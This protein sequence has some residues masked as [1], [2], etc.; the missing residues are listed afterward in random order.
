[1]EGLDAAALTILEES[2]DIPEG[3]ARQAFVRKRTEGAPLLRARVETLLG[4][5][6]K[7]WSS[8]ATEAFGQAR[9]APMALPERVGPFRIVGRIADGGM[10]SV[11]RGERDDGV[12]AQTVAIKFIRG[13]ISAP[14]AVARFDAERRILARLDH[15]SIARV[16]DGGTEAGRPWLAMEFV[17]G[18]PLNAALEA[19]DA[20][21]ADR[22]ATFLAVCE[23]VAFA[24]RNLIVHADIKPG[25]I[26]M[27]AD[28]AIKLL[29]FGIAR[30]IEDSEGD[31][32]Y[33]LT[34]G[35]A[36][37]ERA[38]G[39]APTIAGDVFSLGVLLRE[40]VPPPIPH[41][42]EAIAAC[43]TASDPA[44]RYPDVAALIADVRAYL[45]HF[46]VSA[47]RTSG[48]LYR[49]AK[50]LRRHRAGAIV[51]SAIL[52]LLATATVVSTGLYFRAEGARIE[53]E[54]RFL[55]VRDL[56]RFMLFDLYDDLADSPGT[57][58]SRARLAQMARF[59]LERLQQ[60]PNPPVDLRLDIAR[61][62][63]RLAA[64][65]GLSGV[66]SLGHPDRARDAL[67]RAEAVAA[68]ILA[69]RPD[70]AGAMEEMG[71]VL[72]GRWSLSADN[73][74]GAALN[75][76]GADWFQR[77]LRLEPGRAG[78][79]LGLLTARKN[80]GYDLV[81]LDRSAEAVPVLRAGLD[82]LRAAHF[83]PALAR[84]ARTLEVNMLGR[85]GD[86]VYYAGDVS[87]SLPWYREQ[88]RIV[89]AELARRQSVVW[90]DKLGESKFNLSGTL[91]EMPGHLPE[92]LAEAQAGVA[93]IERMLSFG[94]D[95]NLQMRLLILYSQEAL[96]LDSLGR[97][98]E[99]AAVSQ[100]SVDLRQTRLAGALQDPQRRRDLAAALPNHAGILAHAGRR[101]AAC[102]AARQAIG[103]WQALR[104]AGDLSPRDARTEIP[105][106]E[107]AVRTHCGWESGPAS[108]D[109]KL[110]REPEPGGLPAPLDGGFRRA[111]NDC[112]FGNAEADEIAK[113]D[114]AGELRRRALQLHQSGIER[115]HVQAGRRIDFEKDGRRLPL[116]A[117]FLADLVDHR[118]AQDARAGG[119]EM[120]AIL[121]AHPIELGNAHRRLVHQFGRLQGQE[122]RLAPQHPR[123]RRAQIVVQLGQHLV[124]L[125]PVVAHRRLPPS[126]RRESAPRGPACP[127]DGNVFTPSAAIASGRQAKANAW[128]LRSRERSERRPGSRYAAR[129]ASP[130]GGAGRCSSLWRRSGAVPR[131]GSRRRTRS[132]AGRGRG[133]GPAARRPV[134][135]PAVQRRSVRASGERSR[136][137]Q[138]SAAAS[139]RCRARNRTASG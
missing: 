37:P 43:A 55:E 10:G 130:P 128:R 124:A 66:S 95:S 104:S 123:G 89:R 11:A 29:D 30:L 59:Y 23:A 121:P 17:D 77:A 24:H 50:F 126:I 49:A 48:R 71:W 25:N 8:L 19:R 81:R 64:V 69:E 35:Y 135:R 32:A 91:Q 92:A 6:S 65:E 106:A 45:G 46:P 26:L 90:T 54:R 94:A 73:A 28:G 4:N 53:A 97:H 88:D 132:G 131:P 20:P 122:G 27:R 13:D 40:T 110:A 118:L 72:L 114:D 1:M 129:C 57:V 105:P 33:P 80:R 39:V 137:R 108:G 100:R 136:A 102:A 47:R 99:A 98:D 16:I 36:A 86:A 85:L 113:L 107:A 112:D 68:A 78:A 61:G 38:G 138:R 2:L 63:R 120:L 52:V 67:D 70:Q 44:R 111:G 133:R 5:A 51:T 22:L 139:N 83:P 21:L 12:Y 75:L 62:W 76:R 109:L 3:E 115:L 60:V 84:E 7:Q 103:L 117:A 74:A 18:A 79:M 9:A 34:P 125:G 31:E 96:V 134:S 42:L 56:S 14:L 82:A 101:E 58:T 87:S 127:I 119:E 41:D 93:P 15:P 116:G